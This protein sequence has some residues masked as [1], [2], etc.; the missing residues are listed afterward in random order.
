MLL[1]LLSP[2][3]TML[4]SLTAKPKIKAKDTETKKDE[5]LVLSKE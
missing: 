1:S 5:N 2:D 4:L 3:Y